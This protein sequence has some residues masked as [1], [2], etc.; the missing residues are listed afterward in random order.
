MLIFAVG[1]E[2][3]NRSN[4]SASSID[5]HDEIADKLQDARDVLPM[6]IDLDQHDGDDLL[7]NDVSD[8]PHVDVDLESELREFL[9]NDSTTL[10]AAD[11]VTS[12]DQILM[13]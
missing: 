4:Q 2:P 12:I 11:D 3:L 13:S 10:A 9:E 6:D 7:A 8:V 1:L 5:E